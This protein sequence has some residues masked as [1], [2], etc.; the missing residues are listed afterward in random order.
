[1]QYCSRLNV[2]AR[3]T[4]SRM[5][6]N[7]VALYFFLSS[8]VLYSLLKEQLHSYLSLS[9]L[10]FREEEFEGEI[11]KNAYMLISSSELLIVSLSSS[12]KGFS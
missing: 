10:F 6:R 3:P 1:M 9:F 11:Y 4:T 5:D 2:F 12:N 8:S 7:N